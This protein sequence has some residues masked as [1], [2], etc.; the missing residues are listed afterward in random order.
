[1]A[2]PRNLS[3]FSSAFPSFRMLPSGASDPFRMTSDGLVETGSSSDRRTD[4]DGAS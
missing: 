3:A 1:M 4:G 2:L